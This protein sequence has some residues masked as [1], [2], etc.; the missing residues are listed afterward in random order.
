MESSDSRMQHAA[1]SGGEKRY[2][3]IG[4][5][6]RP[7]VYGVALV[8]TAAVVLSFL[9]ITASSDPQY[10][11]FSLDS[12]FVGIPLLFLSVI[13][14]RGFSR[15]G[16]WPTVWIGAGSL[17]LGLVVFSRDLLQHFYGINAM[18][19]TDDIS[20]FLS[21]ILYLQGAF[22]I[23]NRIPDENGSINRRNTITQTYIIVLAGIVFATMVSIFDILPPFIIPGTG[24][25]SLRE[26]IL[27]IDALL[28]FASSLM[29]L[30]E[31]LRTRSEL[32]FWF[33]MALLLN[34]LRCICYLFEVNIGTP[35]N[36]IGR[37]AVL[38]GGVYF[39]IAAVVILKEAREKHVGSGEAMVSLLQRMEAML[40]ESEG[41]F[42]K[43]FHSSPNA[44]AIFSLDDRRFEDAN[45]NFLRLFEY[46]K[47]ELLDR[48][49]I[50]LNVFRS[51][52]NS[53]T[54]TDLLREQG[55]IQN[56][57]TAVQTKTGKLIPI[58][59]YIEKL[60]INGKNYFIAIIVDIT[61]RKRMENLIQLERDKLIGILN[62]MEDGVAIIN[63][64]FGVEYVNPSM[65]T[66]FGNVNNLKCYEYYNNRNDVC[67]WC[68][69][70]EVFGG[71]TLRREA[72][73]SKTGRIYE[74]TDAPL[75]NAGGKVSKLSVFHDI[76]ERKNVE[77]MKDEF[78]GMVSHELRTPLTII[79]GAAK[80]AMAEGIN[81]QEARELLET[82]VKG[83]ESMAHLVNNMLELSRYQANRLML[84]QSRLDI[85]RAIKDIVEKERAH[86]EGHRVSLEILEKLPKVEAD[87]IRLEHILHNLLDNAAKYSF[88]GTDIHV[89]IKKNDS[90]V[91][92]GISDKGKG[93]S[94]DE[95]GKLFQPFERLSETSEVKPGLG[96]GLL[97]CRRLVEAQGGKIWVE[98]Q[99]N[100][101]STFWFTLPI[102][103]DE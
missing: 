37:G 36:W 23:I 1:L 19:T 98:S 64:D 60:E 59:A 85:S 51:H 65:Q 93:I 42:S 96:L 68:Y 76:T 52:G 5:L 16:S 48:A 9:N 11:V 67:P 99:A 18:V 21:G 2:G 50:A 31:Y 20:T 87:Q 90:H 12:I 27:A 25:T 72:K 40:K 14:A 53:K 54:I 7:A 66:H 39:F 10:L 32:L 46:N 3:F 100:K 73:S 35:L 47:E 71:K 45:D 80:T 17:A 101:G 58:L 70:R 6:K 4:R 26:V 13:A 79:L 97:V 34:V 28:F 38:L 77:Q 84:S 88:R 102:V 43:I 91:M 94:P 61:E 55:R 103:N 49:F 86:I 15:T 44:M 63:P 62:S 81:G 33:S 30:S 29:I 69:I 92:I 24:S 78:L 57:E 82:T 75:E 74:I 83:A 95:Q 56:Y 41:R 22:L 8:F 89:L